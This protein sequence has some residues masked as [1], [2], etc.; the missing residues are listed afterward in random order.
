MAPIDTKLEKLSD[1]KLTKFKDQNFDDIRASCFSA[2]TFWTD[3]EFGP[4]KNSLGE[5]LMKDLDKEYNNKIE[6]KRVHEIS[7]E[8]RLFVKGYCE[9]DV[10]QGQ[11]DDC[12]FISS[13]ASLALQ[14]SLVDK[15]IP[16][17][18]QQELNR[19]DYCGV[20][21]FRFFRFGKWIEVVVDDYL[22]TS[23]NKLVL[24]HSNIYKRNEFWAAFLEKAYAKLDGSYGGLAGG[25]PADALDDLTGGISEIIECE[26]VRKSE[27]DRQNVYRQLKT[28]L[29]R[30]SVVSVV[31][32]QLSK[33]EETS[34]NKEGL[35]SGHAY[36]LIRCHD[37]S[38]DLKVN[39]D[40]R[41]ELLKIRNPWGDD[42]VKLGWQ[43][44]EWTGR[45][46]KNPKFWS[47]VPQEVKEA[48]PYEEKLD[49]EFWMEFDDF[50]DIFSDITICRIIKTD[51]EGGDNCWHLVQKYSSWIPGSTAGG[52]GNNLGTF[53]TN[54]QFQF[55]IEDEHDETV[56]IVLAQ[57]DARSDPDKANM[58]IGFDIYKVDEG[59]K[60]KLNKDT[61]KE[62][63]RFTKTFQS[64]RQLYRKYKLDVGTY[65]IIPSTFDPDVEGKFLLRIFTENEAH[66]TELPIKD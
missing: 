53:F 3:P 7:K 2:K 50:I 45:W 42:Q 63:K 43:E 14:H 32:D 35:Y 24:G 16:H 10:T 29:S 58:S 22:P 8:A 11:L 12:W 15:V 55:Q 34:L 40:F 1:P 33:E 9:D 17:P 4:T 54:P 28:A 26:E 51:P 44:T 36:S 64:L 38:Q 49:G 27:S 48:L 47:K 57:P 20:L 60:E 31:I 56:Q 46:G 19:D 59:N 25:N 37:L 18:D 30:G 66:V 41:K 21:L 13:V 23:N 5:S 39:E 6:W 52:C 61:E 62:Q 65:V